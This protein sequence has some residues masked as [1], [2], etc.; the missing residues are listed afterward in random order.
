MQ[1]QYLGVQGL[2]WRKEHNEIYQNTAIHF[3]I[4]TLSLI[5]HWQK[6]FDKGRLNALFT[7]RG[8][9]PVKKS[10]KYTSS[11]LSELERL[12]IENH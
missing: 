9:P 7:K 4:A 6:S 12:R 10:V 1:Y 11:E 8:R 5:A 2:N 3:K